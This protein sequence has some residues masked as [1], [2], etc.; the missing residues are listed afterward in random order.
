LVQKSAE[1]GYL[2]ATGY[3]GLGKI[4]LYLNLITVV[5]NSFK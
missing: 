5:L 4:M 2:K 1:D 3:V